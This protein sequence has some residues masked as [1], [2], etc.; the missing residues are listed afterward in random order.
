VAC[1]V[2]SSPDSHGLLLFLHVALVS[3]DSHGL[4]IHIVPAVPVAFTTPR[5]IHIWFI[6][7]DHCQFTHHVV[8]CRS[9]RLPRTID[10]FLLIH[11]LLWLSLHS[12]KLNCLDRVACFQS[13][14]GSSS[15][16]WS[17]DWPLFQSSVFLFQSSSAAC[18]RRINWL[19]GPIVGPCRSPR[20]PSSILLLV[21]VHRWIPTVCLL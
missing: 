10:S 3:S 16:C 9:Y 1:T 18:G 2:D 21:A 17:T 7:V 19:C 20:S 11:Y 13:T 15:C 8:P 12:C 6:L 5:L 14:L 4:S